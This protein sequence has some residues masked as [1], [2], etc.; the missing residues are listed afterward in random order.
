VANNNKAIYIVIFLGMLCNQQVQSV[1]VQK[2]SV[3]DFVKKFPDTQLLHSSGK[4]FFDFGKHPLFEYDTNKSIVTN[5]IFLD[6]FIITV[7]RGTVTI[8]SI[9]FYPIVNNCFITEMKLKFEEPFGDLSNVKIPP[10]PLRIN[11][12]VAV[13]SNMY[14]FCYF[15]WINDLVSKLALLELHGIEYDYICIPQYKPY[16]KE[17]LEL[18]GIASHKIIH[19]FVGMHIQADEIIIP[20][21]V[22]TI[23]SNA[24]FG[25]YMQ[26]MIM[27]CI[28]NKMIPN[29]L[30][31]SQN[32]FSSKVFI[33]RKDSGNKRVALNEDDVFRLFEAQGFSR[34]CLAEMPL[35]DQIAL[36]H[37]ATEIVSFHGAGLTNIIFC[38]PNTRIIEIFQKHFDVSYWGFSKMLQL[39]YDLIDATQGKLL[40]NMFHPSEILSLDLVE[41]FLKNKYL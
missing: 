37:S 5:D 13:V 35:A 19:A 28:R 22:S 23:S 2:L 39:R 6:S 15:H 32:N 21:A 38:K 3:L 30:E 27:H 12:R 11:G 20:T 33:S 34:Y 4:L 29:A 8:A 26:P 7:P 1:F 36:F 16:M 9:D 25:N 24:I 31:Q 40:S 17:T 41:N 10:I 18:W 14:E